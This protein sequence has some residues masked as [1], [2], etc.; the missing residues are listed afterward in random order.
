MRLNKYDWHDCEAASQASLG[1]GP[2]S[3]LVGVHEEH[4]PRAM[5]ANLPRHRAV[6]RSKATESSRAPSGA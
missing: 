5:R 6:D 4:A 1:T 2:E 3:C